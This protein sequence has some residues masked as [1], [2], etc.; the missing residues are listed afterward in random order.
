MS[1]VIETVQDLAG[2]LE[3]TINS[4][5]TNYSRLFEFWNDTFDYF[6]S[7]QRRIFKSQRPRRAFYPTIVNRVLDRLHPD[8]V[9]NFFSGH[10]GSLQSSLSHRFFSDSGSVS[11]E[12]TPWTWVNVDLLPIA[13][14]SNATYL[15]ET[16]QLDKEP[17]DRSRL[18]FRNRF[19]NG[20]MMHLA[21][22]LDQLPSLE[23]EFLSLLEQNKRPVILAF[24]GI[25]NLPSIGT[26]KFSQWWK[27]FGNLAVKSVGCFG[28]WM[29]AGENWKGLLTKVDFY[30]RV[31]K[32]NH[33]H[34]LNYCEMRKLV[35]KGA[36]DS[37]ST[38][39]WENHTPWESE[40]LLKV[41]RY[42]KEDL[43][44][45]VIRYFLEEQKSSVALKFVS[46]F[47]TEKGMKALLNLLDIENMQ[48]IV[49]YASWNEI[50]GFA[51]NTGLDSTRS[52]VKTLP[53]GI[54]TK[55]SLD[56]L[57]CEENEET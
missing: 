14:A 27:A 4:Y 43:E 11:K 38:I 41:L 47:A 52:F 17:L 18:G 22:D 5:I 26:N 40:D 55:E 6:L 25:M 15:Q 42:H 29:E 39:L 51:Q 37:E 30:Q 2:K 24:D 7:R 13:A 56:A 19:P 20:T 21:G 54:L 57:K 34:A 46:S 50:I 16:F 33:G 44:G 10:I 49:G 53:F 9:V 28:S 32:T 1:R 48:Q 23:K 36:Y 8:L 35:G 31:L 45:I 3:N 12:Q